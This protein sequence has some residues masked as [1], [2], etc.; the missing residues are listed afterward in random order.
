MNGIKIW[1]VCG[2]AA[3]VLLGGCLAK[4]GVDS[5]SEELPVP[6]QYSEFSELEQFHELL[7]ENVQDFMAAGIIGGLSEERVQVLYDS[8]GDINQAVEELGR[9]NAEAILVREFERQGFDY[10]LSVNL[11]EALVQTCIEWENGQRPRVQSLGD[12]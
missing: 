11:T 12:V 8:V 2:L 4:N 7:K 3:V 1:C 10:E 6:N 9:K 5:T